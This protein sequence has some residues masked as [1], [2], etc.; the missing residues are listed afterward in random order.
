MTLE[1]ILVIPPALLMNE[2]NGRAEDDLLK[3]LKPR[4][5]RLLVSDST[6]QELRAKRKQS[7][8]LDLFLQKM[9]A[10]A[11]SRLNAP[12]LGYQKTGMRL[13]A[14]SR[15][16]LKRILLWSLGYHLTGDDQFKDRAEQEMLAA[17]AFPNWNPSHFLDVGEMT[18]ALAIGYDWLYDVLPPRLARD[19]SPGHR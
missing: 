17:A 15:E 18:A 13:L 8:T 3:G 7:P 16:A 11:R 14:V 9:E 1:R 4:H 19:H 6:W 12:P 2:N 5:P 10:E